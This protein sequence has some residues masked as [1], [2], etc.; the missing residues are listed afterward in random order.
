MRSG[1]FAEGHDG[2]KQNQGE[3][4]DA[5]RERVK[6]LRYPTHLMPGVPLYDYADK[7]GWFLYDYTKGDDNG[8][9]DDKP[10]SIKYRIHVN[11]VNRGNRIH[12]WEEGGRAFTVWNDPSGDLKTDSEGRRYFEFELWS[13]VSK[14][15]GYKFI[16]DSGDS[17]IEI[18]AWEKVT[19]KDYDYE[20]TIN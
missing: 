2:P 14:R 8:F 20:Y 3:S 4:N 10:V 17:W 7:D 11:A 13:P 19:G 5:Y 9:V 18:S 6:K 12:V 1:L 15:I 16:N